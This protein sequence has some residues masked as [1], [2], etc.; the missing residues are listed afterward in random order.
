MDDRIR[1]LSVR[2]HEVLLL[3]QRG[4]SNKQI[5][6]A[7]HVSPET[8][9]M[10]LKHLYRKLSVNNRVQAVMCAVGS[11]LTLTALP[12]SPI[13]ESTGL[14]RERAESPAE[15]IRGPRRVA[16][17]PLDLT[18]SRSAPPRSGN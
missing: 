15:R 11:G 3:L 5:A 10:T 13:G 12:P 1:P 17:P 2:E 9:K 7:I 4:L 6:G 14:D 18:A 16:T 8:V